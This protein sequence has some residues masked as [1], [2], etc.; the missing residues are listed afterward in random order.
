MIIEIPVRI[1]I[2]PECKFETLD[3][4]YEELTNICHKDTFINCFSDKC[5]FKDKKC[6]EITTE[7]WKKIIK[8]I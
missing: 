1:E 6:G 5:L 7:D 2:G 3:Q 8:I 4:L